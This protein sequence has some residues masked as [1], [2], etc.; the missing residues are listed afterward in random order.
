MNINKSL[1]TF[2]KSTT[3]STSQCSKNRSG[4][5]L[6]SSL[7]II[8]LAVSLAIALLSYTGITQ[9]KVV[10]YQQ[11]TQQY[12][13]TKEAYSKHLWEVTRQKEQEN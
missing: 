4:F 13:N 12:H 2:Y 1:K 5:V 8:L 3:L 7:L 9:K 6:L 10:N 11:R